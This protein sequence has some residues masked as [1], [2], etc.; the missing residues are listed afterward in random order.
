MKETQAGLH[1]ALLSG[2]GQKFPHCDQCNEILHQ[3]NITR[4]GSEKPEPTQIKQ[5]T[6]AN[7][8]PMK[9]KTGNTDEGNTSKNICSLVED[10]KRNKLAGDIAS[11]C[12]KKLLLDILIAFSEPAQHKYKSAFEKDMVNYGRGLKQEDSHKL[13]LLKENSVSILSEPSAKVSD[14]LLCD[15][16]MR[17]VHSCHTVAERIATQFVDDAVKE[18]KKIKRKH[19][20]KADKIFPLFPEAS[21]VALPV[22]L[23]LTRELLCAEY[24]VTAN[25]NAFP[26][27][28]ESSRHLCRRADVSDV[29]I[30]ELCKEESQWTY[31]DDDELTVK[32][33]MTEDIFGSLIL[34]TIRVLNKI[35]LK[36]PVILR[37]P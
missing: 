33:R 9:S 22:I 7:V 11:E 21:P 5:R 6:L 3:N 28:R 8:L 34:D 32:M 14:V 27:M 15:S 13:F 18:Y 35:Y 20:L 2:K 4:L 1:A 16:D 25:P 31:Y 23:D 29:K 10:Q 26:W 12:D 37:F 24:Q 19:G 36:K 17:S 30:Q